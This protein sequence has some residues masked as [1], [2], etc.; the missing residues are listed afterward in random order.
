M[1]HITKAD[2]IFNLD[3]KITLSRTSNARSTDHELIL[4]RSSFTSP[5][6]ITKS[7]RNESSNGVLLTFRPQRGNDSSCKPNLKNENLKLTFRSNE[8]FA[9]VPFVLPK[10]YSL[11]R[12]ANAPNVILVSSSRWNF[13]PHQLV[14]Y[15][16]VC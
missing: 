7:T 3:Y 16:I 2:E 6:R 5:L 10:G 4:R 14:A 9:E 15:Q 12:R 1:K 13:D 11:C 8:C